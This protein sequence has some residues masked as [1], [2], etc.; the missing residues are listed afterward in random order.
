MIVQQTLSRYHLQN[1]IRDF[2][3]DL[4]FCMIYIL[5]FISE[6]MQLEKAQ[7]M[8]FNT[9]DFYLFYFETI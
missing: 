1:M 2:P 6:L 8:S 9:M 7:V 4:N 3:E 5:L